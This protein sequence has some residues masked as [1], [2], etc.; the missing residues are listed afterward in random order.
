MVSVTV[1]P[2]IT[3]LKLL[4]RSV[5]VYSLPG[6]KSKPLVKPLKVIDGEAANAVDERLMTMRSIRTSENT[7]LHD[8]FIIAAPYQFTLS[9]PSPSPATFQASFT[10]L[11][12]VLWIASAKTSTERVYSG[13]SGHVTVQVRRFPSVDA[14]GATGSR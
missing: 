9:L 3:F 5:S 11:A 12:G 4:N 13:V 14:P 2:G 10:A 6:W 7:A 1:S 8:F